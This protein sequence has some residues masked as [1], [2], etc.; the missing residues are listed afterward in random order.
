MERGLIYNWNVGDTVVYLLGGDRTMLAK[1][2]SRRLRRDN[3]RPNYTI[4]PFDEG[5]HYR[6]RNVASYSL[7]HV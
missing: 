3:G 6:R 1:V 2:T 5:G 7:R 4:E